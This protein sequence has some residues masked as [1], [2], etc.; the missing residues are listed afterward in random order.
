MQQSAKCGRAILRGD[1]VICIVQPESAGVRH[2]IIRAGKSAMI[3]AERARHFERAGD[4]RQIT[5][6][7]GIIVIP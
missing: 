7:V 6:S 5:R 4:H 2:S 3:S 1:V